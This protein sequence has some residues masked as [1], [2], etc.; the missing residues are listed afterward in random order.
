MSRVWRL[1]GAIICLGLALG[2]A[3]CGAAPEDEL[4]QWMTAQRAQAAPRVKPIAPPKPFKAQGYA[5]VSP[6]DPFDKGKLTAALQ[7]E[8]AQNSASEARIAPELK[9][10]KEPLED[11]PLDGMT[12][13]GTM[14]RAGQTVALI[15]VGNALH[16]VKVGAH[17][18]QNYG[19]VLR[20][21]ETELSLRELVQDAAGDWVERNASLQLQ[22][23]TK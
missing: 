15:K 23:R 2:L 16:T 5:P 4:Q 10:R 18:G 13:V 22:Q 7:R 17:L 3:A 8:R 9:R 6:L 21:S 14:V 11:F 20:I 12:L 1:C 19:Q